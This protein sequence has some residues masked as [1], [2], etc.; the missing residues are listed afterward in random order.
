MTDDLAE[1]FGAPPLLEGENLEAFQSLKSHLYSTV[2]PTDI[3]E[4]LWVYDLLNLVW[5]TIRLRRLRAHLLKASAPDGLERVILPIAPNYEKRKQLIQEWAQG[6]SEAIEVAQELCK[7]GGHNQSSIDARALAI[8]LKCFTTIDTMISNADARR[9]VI[10][11]ELDR[12]RDVLARR[13]SEVIENVTEGALIGDRS[14]GEEPC[15]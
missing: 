2:K 11:R 9:V 6:D 1:I 3:I 8:N 14:T 4:Q 12:H 13:L 15:V 10:L 5:E 7:L